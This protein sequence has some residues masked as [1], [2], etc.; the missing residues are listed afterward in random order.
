MWSIVTL[1]SWWRKCGITYGATALLG[2][3]EG[4]SLS[5]LAWMRSSYDLL[6]VVP[7]SSRITYGVESCVSDYMKSLSEFSVDKDAAHFRIGD[8]GMGILL[9]VPRSGAS[10]C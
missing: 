9:M 8:T 1:E 6:T 2:D 7:E 4:E 5:R 3:L 10:L